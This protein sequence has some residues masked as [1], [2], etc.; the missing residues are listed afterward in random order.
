MRTKSKTIAAALVISLC[1]SLTAQAASPASGP[2]PVQKSA[3]TPAPAATVPATAV[4][5]TAAAATISAITSAAPVSVLERFRTYSGPRTPAA[6][7]ELFRAPVWAGVRQQPE[8]VI[9]NGAVP[10]SIAATISA[11]DNTA[12]NFAFSGAR[13]TS[14]VQ[15][16]IDEWLIEALP[17]TGV[18]RSELII[19]SN[20]TAMEIPLTV[21]PP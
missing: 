8:I 12:P 9:S 11:K 7:S 1:A 16:K 10:V 4:P 20:G 13:L 3:S 21:A 19:L 6:L 5:A 15:T 18:M 2:T 17:E 14:S